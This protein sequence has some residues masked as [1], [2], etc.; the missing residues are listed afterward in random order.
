MRILLY[1]DVHISQNSSIINTRGNKYS[2]RLENIIKSLNWAEKQAIVNKCDSIICLGDL[3]DRSDLNAEEITALKE[4]KWANLPHT[5]IVGNHESNVVSLDFSSAFSLNNVFD[6]I[7]KPCSDAYDD[8][9]ITYLPYIVESE[10]KPIKEYLPD[11]KKKIIL[12]HNDIKGI[13]YGQWVS[14]DGFDIEDI[15]SNCD[16]F[17]NGHLHNGEWVNN[18]ILNLGNLTGANFSEDAFRYKHQ[19][20]IL[21]TNTLKVEFI[22]NPYAFNFYKLEIKSKDD[23]KVL[24]TLKNAVVSIK[25]SNDLLPLVKGSLNNVIESRV[26]IINE[27]VKT[28]TKEELVQVDHLKQFADYFLTNIDGSETA[29][30]EL[31][32]IVGA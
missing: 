6:I 32:I 13:Q 5:L 31:A 25:C 7:N 30:S 15:N 27:A 9:S 8:F 19:I 29:K 26:T 10:R 1:T 11:S 28:E 2:T 18:K 20:A 21:D 3:F 14:K 22:E 23:L 17:I 24:D 12:S 4:I 16:L